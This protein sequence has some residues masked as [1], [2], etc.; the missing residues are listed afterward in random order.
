MQRGAY[1]EPSKQTVG[2]F[3][4]AWL[5]GCRVRVRPST[6]ASY[7]LNVQAHIIPALGTIPLQSVTA[8]GLN[9]FYADLLQAGR[10]GR[11]GGL[12]PRTVRYVHTILRRALADAVRQNR[13]SRN[14][15]DLADPPPQRGAQA[16]EMK[17]WTAGE[18]RAFLDYAADDR[19]YPAFLLA[20]TTG[21]RRGEIAGLRW[22]D[23]DLEAGRLAVTQ[24]LISL[25]N[26]AAVS[27]PKT[28]K[29]RRQVALDG[30]TAAV[31]RAHR[32]RQV[33][34]RL[35]WGPAYQDGDL[36]F[37]REDGTPI[38]PALLSERFERLAREAD[39]PRIRFHDLRHTHATLS[40]QA[41][42]HPKVVSERLGHASVAITLDVYSHA[43]AGVQEE[44][45]EKVAALVLGS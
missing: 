4:K 16:P 27:T 18:L 36:V 9:A 5:D 12:S 44:A 21:M 20:A 22:R 11:E 32:R 17:T 14:V 35:A 15:A 24:T 39:L 38:N 43:V 40:L 30:S 28:A 3:L 45:A 23:V 7:R 1:V 31:L 8:A 34:E 42:V 19:L 33:E 2:D 29:G 26:K 6:W 37:C 10:V 41:G 25:G 13:L